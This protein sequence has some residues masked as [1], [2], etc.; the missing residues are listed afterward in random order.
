MFPLEDAC[1]TFVHTVFLPFWLQ[2]FSCQHCLI[3]TTAS[4]LLYLMCLTKQQALC[5]H[6]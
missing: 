6:R 3:L 1:V 2:I 4:L 5:K